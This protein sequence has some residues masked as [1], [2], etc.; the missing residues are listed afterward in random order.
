MGYQHTFYAIDIEKL[1]KLFGSGDESLLEAVVKEKSEELE[2]NDEFFE[3]D[4]DDGDCPGSAQALG[5][6]IVLG[7]PS[8]KDCP[9]MY[10]YVLGI[11][12]DHL[13]EFLDEEIVC[14]SDHPYE[15]RLNTSGPPVP[16][17]YDT[18]DF[19][20]IG[21]LSHADIPAEISRIDAAPKVDDEEI[22]E[23][24]DAY[25][26]MLE[27]VHSKKLGLVSLRH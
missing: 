4:I 3:D 8:K 23:D 11:L 15:S 17:P 12:C 22:A 9:A 21:Y 18:S 13:G 19:P 5:E 1:K 16:I 10:G 26:A 20:E 24:I 7:A 27:D 14:V 25:R 2:D 6:I